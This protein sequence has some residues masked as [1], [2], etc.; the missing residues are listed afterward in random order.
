MNILVTGASGFVGSQLAQSL[1][2]D[3][4]VY[5]LFRDDYP[6][7]MTW[8]PLRGN[9]NDYPRM[10][11]IM[12]NRE[13]DQ[14]Y[15]CASRAIVRNCRLDPLDC[16]HTNVMGTV[17]V[18]ESVRQVD[19]CRAVVIVTSDKCYENRELARGYCEEDAIGGN[20][21]YSSSKGCAEL[22]TA[23]YIN[24]YFPP[25]AYDDH[26]VAVKR[27]RSACSI[28]IERDV[29]N[30]SSKASSD[31]AA[32]HAGEAGTLF[33]AFIVPPL[34]S[35]RIDIGPWATAA[36][37]SLRIESGYQVIATPMEYRRS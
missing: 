8:T 35:H 11:D 32:F 14:V 20:D 4:H 7:N 9:I 27:R 16:F 21:P 6:R 10:L 2:S 23:A 25:D 15:H 31:R 17:N 33:S 5:G 18:L 28:I 22:V 26:G 24:S 1:V 34:V 29:A 13:I 12:V 19:S 30:R 3:H 36:L 37:L